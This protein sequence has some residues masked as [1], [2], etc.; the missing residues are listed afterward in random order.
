MSE[1]FDNVPIVDAET[2]AIEKLTVSE[3]TCTDV[4]LNKIW[5]V[6]N[7]GRVSL[8][9]PAACAM[10]VP[11]VLLC[12]S[13]DLVLPIRNGGIDGV[14]YEKHKYPGFTKALPL[15]SN[16][17]NRATSL[18]VERQHLTFS[19]PMDADRVGRV[20]NLISATDFHWGHALVQLIPSL[21]WCIDNKV[22]GDV[23][24]SYKI[25]E[26]ILEIIKILVDDEGAG[27]GIILC[28]KG[29]SVFCEEAVLLPP[30]F[31][32]TE[33]AHVIS[34]TD[35]IPFSWSVERLNKL[36]N[37]LREHLGIKDNS[38][39]R[40][41]F[42]GRGGYRGAVNADAVIELFRTRG[43]E[44]VGDLMEKYG[45]APTL[46]EK[47]EEYRDVGV[48]AGFAGSA[49]LNL[50][51]MPEGVRSLVI[52]SCARALDIGLLPFGKHS[53]T[54]FQS[55]ELSSDVHSSFIVPLRQLARCLDEWVET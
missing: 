2:F 54:Y 5:G 14:I 8:L 34:G 23:L 55:P 25:D 24:V 16:I 45:R 15:D 36:S 9:H 27:R 30:G 41:V 28:G 1:K 35:I 26:N 19:F 38:G 49:F 11:N 46:K 51:L 29:R 7:G 12:S 10:T 39:G 3:Q 43:F 37:R 52:G 48:L 13:S 47:A 6:S 53:M 20:I 42:M 21:M 40:K 32:I 22:E 33:H 31:Y 4:L 44:I 17:E 50:I 18:F